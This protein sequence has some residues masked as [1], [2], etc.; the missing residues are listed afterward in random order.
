LIVMKFGGTSVADAERIRAVARIVEQHLERRPVVVVSA[1]GGVTDLLEQAVTLAR[2]GD[3]EG[4]DP[5]L[6]DLVRRHRWALA[7]T[8]ETAGLRHDLDLEL[9]AAFDD[10][11]QRLRSIRILGEHTPRAAD[12]VLA[13][14]DLLAA[15]I[16]GAALGCAGLPATELDARGLIVTDET[17]GAAQPALTLTR[18]RVR[19]QILP[20]TEA[21]RVPVVAGFAGS[22]PGG[23]TTTLGRG[24]S[25]TSATVLGLA[26][27]VDEIQIW[28]DV[29]GLMTADPRLVPAARSLDRVSFGEA[30]ELAFAGAR[31][32]H[33]ASIAPAVERQ[34][35]VRVLNSLQPDQPGTVI[36]GQE[37]DEAPPRLASLTSR[38]PVCAVRVVSRELRPD[39]DFAARVHG[40]ARRLGLVPALF[41]AGEMSAMLVTESCVEAEALE[42]SLEFPARVERVEDRT[43]VCAV[44]TGLRDAMWRG[45]VLEALARWEPDLVLLGASELALTMLLHTERLTEALRALHLQFFEGGKSV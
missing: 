40:A 42:R 14:G 39:P 41:V 28:T 37:P 29:N 18:E 20:L 32:L 9:D 25:D 27:E 38:G 15:R 10:L 33:P 2:N 22:S 23:A 34:I 26:L 17:F 8:V 35:P 21:G 44:G 11:R 45:R 36:H 31:V 16:V 24:G 13:L 43:I 12:T 5:I 3:L 19:E 4:L 6:A 1:L 7:G 30:A